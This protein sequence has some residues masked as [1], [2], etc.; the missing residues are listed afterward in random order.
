[1]PILT[2][3]PATALAPGAQAISI[4]PGIIVLILVA[5]TGDGS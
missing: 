5:N 3:S 4:L 2:G 1:M